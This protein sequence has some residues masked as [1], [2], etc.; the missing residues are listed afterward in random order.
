[1]MQVTHETIIEVAHDTDK[2]ASEA[3][4]SVKEPKNEV[5]IAE[6]SIRHSNLSLNIPPRHA[7]FGAGRSDKASLQSPGIL[8]N[9]GSSSRGIF[10]GLSF[11][12]KHPVDG[13][14]SS[15]L[16]PDTNAPPPESPV[17]TN[18]M[19][20]SNW[21]RC[22]S[23]PVKHG[24]NPSPSA[25]TPVSART[26][27][28]TQKS[29]T[30]AVQPSVSRSLSVPGR[31]IVIVRSVSFAARKDNDQIDGHDDEIS[32]VQVEND[33][34]IDEEEAVC[35]ICF[36]TC[37]EGNQLKMECSCK[38]ALKLVHEECAVK[39]FS[40]KGN[41]NCD[42]C[43]REVSNLPVTLLRMPSQVQRQNIT[44]QN[45]QGL[46]PGTISAWQ[47][48]VVLV[49]ISTICYFFFLEQLLIPDLKTQA[50][51]IAAPFSFTFG[52][53]SSTFAVILAIKEYIWTYAAL[54]FA[55][56]AVI[57]HLFYSWLQLKAIYAVMLSSVLG[58][59]FAMT[60]NALYIRFYAWRFQV[61][62]ESITA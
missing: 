10:R 23:L 55:L 48:F 17:V 43:G 6:K 18:F 29:L 33:E 21:K 53:L 35:R 47:D 51:V 26:Y 59:G 61:H 40:V 28:E 9:G 56:V 54:E 3:D 1:M 46:D 14:S 44:A 42:V 12:K 15:L 31:N 62:Q 16:H 41:K 25:T 27:I 4:A 24:S 7:H 58:F 57:L 2:N 60:L 45:Q 32:H 8:S 34:E 39:W 19:S 36:D 50:V 20:T 5:K 37:D 22:T 52:L 49:L 30:R 11:K 13:E 38:G